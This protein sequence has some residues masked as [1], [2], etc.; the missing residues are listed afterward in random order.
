MTIS[1]ELYLQSCNDIRSREQFLET[2]IIQ[3][4]PKIIF[5]VIKRKGFV[6]MPTLIR[7]NRQLEPKERK[8]S[9]GVAIER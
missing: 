3:G 9:L 7:G 4:F 2:S 1:F 5:D 8:K 6:M